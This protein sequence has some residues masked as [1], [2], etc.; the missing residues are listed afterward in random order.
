MLECGFAEFLYRALP[1]SFK[2]QCLP[3]I[4][5]VLCLAGCHGFAKTQGYHLGCIWGSLVRFQ[6]G[7]VVVK[8]D[9]FLQSVAVCLCCVQAMTHS[10]DNVPSQEADKL[11]VVELGFVEQCW[12]N[13]RGVGLF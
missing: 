7:G 9:V 12:L 2:A 1:L 10:F 6:E 8:F 13:S 3:Q 4:K 5:R 11:V